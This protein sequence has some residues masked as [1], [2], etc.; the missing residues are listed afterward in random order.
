MIKS[1]RMGGEKREAPLCGEVLVTWP[2]FAVDDEQIGGALRAAGLRLRLEPKLG[3]RSPEELCRLATGV[4]AAIVS[5]DPFDAAVLAALPD[6]KVIARVG[7]GTDSIDLDA[8]TARGVAVTVAP[9]ANEAVVAEHAVAMMLSLLRRLCEHDRAIRRFQW[10]RT[11][12]A[13][14]WSLRGATVG[15]VGFGQI[16]RL[17]AERLRGFGASLLVCDPELEAAAGEI[18]SVPLAEL[19]ERSDVVSLHCPLLPS[20][21]GLIGAAELASMRPGAVLVNTARGGIVDEDALID[22]LEAGRP[23]AAAL[24][25][26]ETEPPSNPRLLELPN[27]LMSPHNAALSEWSVFEMTRMAAASVLDV[28]SGRVPAK[29]A[30]PGVL[31][32]E[33]A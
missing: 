32:V 14:P 30:N 23:R 4:S 20:T 22:A 1:I 8:A 2:D 13:M 24:D 6:L 18:A 28:L 25:V 10:A 7:V 3:R 31:E 15:L 29:L 26:F 27:L 19:L 16:G 9:G 17:V 11:G 12:D 5:T 21:A 33:R